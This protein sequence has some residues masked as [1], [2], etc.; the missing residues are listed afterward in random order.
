MLSRQ[1]LS[2]LAAC[3]SGPMKTKK[4]LSRGKALLLE[5]S[6]A[7]L[8]CSGNREFDRSLDLLVQAGRSLVLADGL[9]RIDA[10]LL[11]IH[12]D[13]FGGESL[14]QVGSGHRTEELAFLGLDSQ[15]QRQVGDRLGQSLC[16]GKDLGILVGALAQVLGQ[17]LLGR[18]RG[19]LGDALRDQVVV[20]ITGLHVH[21]VVG[22]A[23]I[24]HIFDQNDFH[25]NVL[26]KLFHAI[27]YEGQNGE[28]TR[29]LHG[30]CDLLLELLRGTRQSAG[31][32][33]A[34][35]V[36]ELLEEFAVL[37]INVLDAELL[38]AAVLL[39]LD[40][41]R[42]GVEVTDLRLC[43]VLLCHGLLLLLVRKFCTTFLRI[44]YGVLVLLES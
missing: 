23:Q 17:H 26:L 3:R 33:L 37:V 43:F 38:E 18:S 2:G 15:R 30:L 9:D 25:C 31:K 21:D 14:G 12:R 42:Y 27:G 1:S 36:E 20:C 32:D 22:V 8:F 24:L 19:G 44:L 10:D 28:V 16:V 4:E 39:L 11:A 41:Y 13:A 35:F 6:L 34:L 29:T 5:E 7:T 40:V